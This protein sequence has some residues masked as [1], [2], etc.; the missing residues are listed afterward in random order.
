MADIPV[1]PEVDLDYLRAWAG[2][3]LGIP[4][5]DEGDPV[6]AKVGRLI[7]AYERLKAIQQ[8]AEWVVNPNGSPYFS[9]DHALVELEK[10]LRG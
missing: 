6:G 1:V 10:L 5:T 3:V 9:R 8:A 4:S 2:P 7:A